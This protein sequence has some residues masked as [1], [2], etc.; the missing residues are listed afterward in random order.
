MT[1]FMPSE[2]KSRLNCVGATLALSFFYKSPIFL[3]EFEKFIPTS[4]FWQLGAS[5]KKAKN[6]FYTSTS[7]N[8]IGFCTPPK[9]RRTLS[10]P[11][12]P[13]V[14]TVSKRPEYILPTIWP[15]RE[16]EREIESE[17]S[18]S[19]RPG[20]KAIKSGTTI[21]TFFK[22]ARGRDQKVSNFMTFHQARQLS[23]KEPTLGSVRGWD[24]I[25]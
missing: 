6:T 14:A 11:F 12:V 10:V 24:K 8:G 15:L 16:R 23:R 2:E 13:C 22:R 1:I 7:V 25:D 5:K 21:D 20:H 3:I 19:A 17:C 9:A 18:Q 4:G